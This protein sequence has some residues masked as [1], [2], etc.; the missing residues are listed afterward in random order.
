MCTLNS[1]LLIYL[2]WLFDQL[3]S[4]A[5][6]LEVLNTNPYIFLSIPIQSYHWYDVF[7]GSFSIYKLLYGKELMENERKESLNTQGNQ[8][9]SWYNALINLILIDQQQKNPTNIQFSNDTE[10]RYVANCP[11]SEAVTWYFWVFHKINY[12]ILIRASTN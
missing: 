4:L 1:F 2:F 3:I 10:Q 8:D 7:F 11:I 5:L 12:L 9:I 6:S